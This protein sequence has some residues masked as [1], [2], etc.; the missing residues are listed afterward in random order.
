MV[1]SALVLAWYAVA[2]LPKA[3]D[4]PAAQPPEAIVNSEI[5]AGVADIDPPINEGETR[6]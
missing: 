5:I 3:I 2:H 1:G 4:A 6:A